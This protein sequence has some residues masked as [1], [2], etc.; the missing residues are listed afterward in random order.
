[1]FRQF[2]EP[3][4]TLLKSSGERPSYFWKEFQGLNES[5]PN[6]IMNHLPQV[7]PGAVRNPPVSAQPIAGHQRSHAPQ[8]YAFLKSL[9]LIQPS[10]KGCFLGFFL[11]N[12]NKVF[13]R[14]HLYSDVSFSFS[15][16]FILMPTGGGKS[17]CYQLTAAISDGVSIVISPLVSLIHDQVRIQ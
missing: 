13:I 3:Y 11:Y 12:L 10:S 15:D 7:P 14:D 5:L 9:I 17:L 8:R 16:T 6:L 2:C 4:N 1:M